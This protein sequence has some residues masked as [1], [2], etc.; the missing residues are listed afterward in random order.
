MK[1]SRSKKVS[2]IHVT[3]YGLMPFSLLFFVYIEVIRLYI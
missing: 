3:N 2:H 1:R